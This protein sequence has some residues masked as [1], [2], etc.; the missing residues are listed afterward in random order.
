MSGN[1]Q[2]VEALAVRN[3]KILGAGSLDQIMSLTKNKPTIVN[4]DGRTVFPGFI[5]PHNHVVLSSLFDQLLI[6]VGLQNTKRKTKS[7]HS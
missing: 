4:L 5:D 2:K 1:A 7:S 6:N 3:G